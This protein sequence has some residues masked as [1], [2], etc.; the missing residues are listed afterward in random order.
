MRKI[1][2]LLFIL[3]RINILK[4]LY[5]NLRYFKFFDAIKLP[6]LVYPNTILEKVDGE[7]ILKCPV[8][9]G[10]I[11]IGKHGMGNRL[12]TIWLVSGTLIVHGNTHFGSGTKISVG[13][14]AILKIGKNLSIT[15]DSSIICKR[16]IEIGDDCI[17]SWDDLIMDTDFHQIFDKD[18]NLTNQPIP[19]SIGD[20]VWIACRVTVLKGS[21]VPTGSV[22][23]CSSLIAS[24]YE[25]KNSIIGGGQ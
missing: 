12:Q 22:I 8:K 6:I 10:I 18:N 17:I 14:N 7:I 11:S 19:I 5:L 20:K 3:F 9:R 21:I 25:V 23:A 24:K 13:K 2:S 16:Y 1:K 15:G 4:T